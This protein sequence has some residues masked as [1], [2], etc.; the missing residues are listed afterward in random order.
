M[1]ALAFAFALVLVLIPAVSDDHAH[2]SHQSHFHGPEQRSIQRFSIVVP[3]KFRNYCKSN[4]RTHVVG[5]SLRPD[6]R[7]T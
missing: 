6:G 3:T 4:L 2:I 5:L 7:M 1:S